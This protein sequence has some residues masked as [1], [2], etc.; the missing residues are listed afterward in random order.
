MN[1]AVRRVIDRLVGDDRHFTLERRLFN[2]VSLLNAVTNIGGVFGLLGLE[3]RRF[4]VALNLGTGLLFL[5][6]YVLSRFRGVYR[7]LYWPFV[8]TIAVFLFANSLGNA[9]SL[10]GAFSY[11]DNKENRNGV[12]NEN[13]ARELLELH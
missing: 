4:L 7:R 6:F 10:G 11:F 1:G 12:A 2:S 3:N 5:L 9:G 8:L 13:Y